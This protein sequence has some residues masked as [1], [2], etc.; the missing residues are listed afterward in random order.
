MR[1]KNEKERETVRDNTHEHDWGEQE[2][3]RVRVD[4]KVCVHAV[5]VSVT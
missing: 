4:K 2:V 3:T 1:G 5:R